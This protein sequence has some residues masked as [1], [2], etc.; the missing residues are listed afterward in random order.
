MDL[1]RV[2][3]PEDVDTAKQ[4]IMAVANVPLIWEDEDRSDLYL[5]AWLALDKSGVAASDDM[6]LIMSLI[7]QDI[8]KD[9]EEDQEISLE[10]LEEYNALFEWTNFHVNQYK[11]NRNLAAEIRREESGDYSHHY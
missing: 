4:V 10:S 6:L 7:H 1:T 11:F 8:Q 3:R 9:A 2:I 5:G